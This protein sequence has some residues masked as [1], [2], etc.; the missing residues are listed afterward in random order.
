MLPYKFNQWVIDA[1]WGLNL[2]ALIF[3]AQRL[4]CKITIQG[5]TTLYPPQHRH[6]KN[7][8]SIQDKNVFGPCT[9]HCDKGKRDNIGKS[10]WLPGVNRSQIQHNH[11]AVT[12]PPLVFL[13][14]SYGNKATKLKSIGRKKRTSRCS[15]GMTDLQ[16]KKTDDC[17]KLTQRYTMC[18]MIQYGLYCT[19]K[20][21]HTKKHF[22][23]VHYLY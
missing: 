15:C 17:L 22:L 2:T 3:R 12:F 5:Q 19:K 20:K 18:N 8:L 16:M 9:G 21:H 11:S 1:P 13:W 10:Y 6:Q 4:H 14:L 23:E 7:F